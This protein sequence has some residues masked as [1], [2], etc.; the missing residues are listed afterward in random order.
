MRK[1]N[2]P[3]LVE[4]ICFKGHSNILGLH[5]NTIEVTKEEEISRRADCI[6]GVR[7]TKACSDLSSA[8]RQHIQ[9]GGYLRFE[10]IVEEERFAFRGEGSHN[11]DLTNDRELV[12]RR[13]EFASERTGAI[14][15]DVAAIDIPR[16][17]VKKLQSPNSNGKLKI[18]AV[19]SQEQEDSFVWSLP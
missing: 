18:M 16:S 10:I 19:S 9:R 5:R 2:S 14:K 12:L 6:I 15:C 7:A 17:I 1:E 4:T 13:S 11:L 3:D 8:L